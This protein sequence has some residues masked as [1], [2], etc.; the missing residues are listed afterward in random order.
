MPGLESMEF[1]LWAG[2]QVNA[3]TPDDV[4]AAIGKAFYAAL[5]IPETRKAFESSGNAVLP[6]RTPAE[7]AKIYAT[8]IERYRSIARSINLQP[9]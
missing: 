6:A 9:Q 1:D 7:L 5:D 2:V 8:D 3:N 4:V